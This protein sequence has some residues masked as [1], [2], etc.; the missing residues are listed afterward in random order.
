MSSTIYFSNSRLDGA[1]V[2]L[3]VRSA[4]VKIMISF[5]SRC[6]HAYIVAVLLLNNIV[7]VFML[8]VFITFV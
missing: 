1:V 8:K 2:I 4:R 6:T 7:I 5:I 3:H